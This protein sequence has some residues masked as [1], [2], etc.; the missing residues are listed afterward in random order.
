[1]RSL[2]ESLLDDL[3]ELE[4]EADTIVNLQNKLAGHYTIKNI[5]VSSIA[6]FSKILNKKEVNKLGIPFNNSDNY[7]IYNTL[8]RAISNPVTKYVNM[9]VGYIMTNTDIDEFK[10]AMSKK[11]ADPDSKYKYTI[12]NDWMPDLYKKLSVLF[13][14]KVNMEMIRNDH[15]RLAFYEPNSLFEYTSVEINFEKK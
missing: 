12:L 1:M 6:K 7:I 13:K 4:K 10:Y 14:D 3:D 2:Y 9:L 15:F 5:T 8:H 11:N